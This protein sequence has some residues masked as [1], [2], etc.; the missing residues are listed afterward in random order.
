MA[1]PVAEA[2]RKSRKNPFRVRWEVEVYRADGT[3]KMAKNGENSLIAGFA[4]MVWGLLTYQDAG[5]TEHDITNTLHVAYPMF[6]STANQYSG[7]FVGASGSPPGAYDHGIQVGTNNT[8]VTADDYKLNTI[9]AN[10][11]GGG[12][13]QQMPC[14]CNPVVTDATTSAMSIDRVFLNHS[15]GT[16][17]IKELGIYGRGSYTFCLARD[18]IADPGVDIDDG[19]YMHVRYAI[20]VTE[21]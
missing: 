14:F 20:S 12:Q 4:F 7:V 3:L 6:P 11:T 13:L 5:Y 17:T 8:A 1:I 2:T 16:I 9:V 10:G 15:G 21:A 18:I 19:E